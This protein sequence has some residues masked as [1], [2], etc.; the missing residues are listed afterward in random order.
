MYKNIKIFGRGVERMANKSDA[1]GGIKLDSFQ[2]DLAKR[3]I[4]QLN[5]LGQSALEVMTSGGKSYIAAYIMHNYISM[6]RNA[7]ILWLAPKS[8]IINV[9]D[10]IFSKT[11]LRNRIHYVGYE[12]L[13]RGSYDLESKIEDCGIELIVFD[14]CHKAYAK[15]T[16]QNLLDLLDK[17]GDADRLAMSATPTRYD[18]KNTFSVLVPKVLEPIQFDLKDAAEHDLLP[19]LQYIL[20]NTNICDSDFKEVERYKKLAENNSEAKGLYEDVI[21]TLSTFKFDL[22]KDLGELLKNYIHSTGECGERH[23]AFLPSIQVLTDKKGEI[24][25]AFKM[26]YPKC[27]INMLEY[28]S[29]LTDVENYETFKQFVLDEPEPNRI[30]VMLS[31]DKATESIHP[32]NVRTVL[33]F[34]GTQSVRVYL[35]QMG[36]GL[37][38]KSYHPEDII[39]FDFADDVSCVGTQ[40]SGKSYGKVN[41][42]GSLSGGRTSDVS[43]IRR[44]IMTQFGYSKG[45]QTEI[46]IARIQDCMRKLK[47]ITRI[48]NLR[49]LGAN[50]DRANKIFNKLVSEEASEP[51]EN[52]HYMISEIQQEGEIELTLKL[53]QMWKSDKESFNKH[54]EKVSSNFTQYQKIFLESDKC[55]NAH[56]REL[57]ESLGHSAYLVQ[58]NGQASERMLKDIDYIKAEIDKHGNLENSSNTH[59]KHKLKNLRLQYAKNLITPNICIYARRNGIDIEMHNISIADMQYLCESDADKEVVNSFRPIARQLAAFDKVI[60]EGGDISFGD[61]LECIVSLQLKS[62]KYRDNEMT[63]IYSSYIKGK[64]N[65]IINAYKLSQAEIENG[66]KLM[67]AIFKVENNEL[68]SRLE[69]DYIFAHHNMADLSDYEEQILRQSS[70]NK[71][72][73]AASLENHTEFMQKYNKAIEGDTDAIKV[74]L[75]YDIEK[76]DD[77]RKKLLNDSEFLKIQ[78]QT[79]DTVGIEVLV[80]KAKMMCI[81]GEDYSQLQEEI[82][83]ELDKG[84]LSQ[85]DIAISPFRSYDTAN[86]ITL[87]NASDEEF[88]KYVSDDNVN[89]LSVL[90]VRCKEKS[91][92]AKETIPNI[93]AIRSLDE[94]YKK[95]LSDILNLIM[96]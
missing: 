29:G 18:G 1:K 42:S 2:L 89:I 3:V 92:C 74:M 67:S 55:E 75:T 12:E 43:S 30:D 58:G 23:I 24:E 70:I 52:I 54:W 65:Y 62:R 60:T 4:E 64:Y 72:N 88:E 47:Q 14:E 19:N 40:S 73:Y 76:L 91:N 34:R 81:T 83:K 10:K 25:A 32:D 66:T 36:R 33:L 59:A 48:A 38:L 49:W 86:I 71:R 82:S 69:E 51:T 57:F 28:H 11:A 46:G 21:K 87:L 94:Q 50:I 68:P 39:I 7:S 20:A 15:K 13:A 17:L 31:V 93:I 61:W 26:A 45:L 85:L 78:S 56:L 95:R 27:K 77:R 22:E 9:K 90:I 79:K 84:T 5:T 53:S 37:M 16:Y 41:A 44:E 80:H 96:R 6:H 63:Y 35:Q 8:A